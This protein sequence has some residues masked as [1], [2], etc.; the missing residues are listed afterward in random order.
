[1]TKR[2][3]LLINGINQRSN[4]EFFQMKA[5]NAEENATS[6]LFESKKLANAEVYI[7]VQKAMKGVAP[8]YTA[9][10]K[11]AA[12]Q[13]EAHLNRSHGSAVH[14]KRQGSVMTNTHILKDNDIDLVQ[15]TNKSKAVD[16]VRLKNSLANPSTLNPLEF[17][18]LK[19]H[20]D[21]FKQYGG[22]QLSDLQIL[23][24]KSEEILVSTYKEV[25]IEKDKSIY[26][27]VTSPKRDVDVV[28]ATYYK[29]IDYMKTNF[30]YRRGIQIFNK[31]LNSLSDVDYPFWSIKRI[32]ER[33]ILTNGRLK[34]MIRFL[35]NVKYDCEYINNKGAIRSFHLNAIC[36][37]I[38]VERYQYAHFLDL[39]PVINDELIRI[40]NDKTY[41]DSI[42]SVDGTEIIFEKDCD[43]KLQEIR[44]LQNEI[45]QIVTD[46]NLNNQIFI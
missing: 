46:L 21:D 14:F 32:N 35:K 30:E 33:S 44:F 25:D 1:M 41:R 2:Y 31:K 7:Y 19:K 26:I 36:Y 43:K 45:D 42:K 18:N 8:Q 39:V 23:R 40:L 17:K 3:D 22:N 15:I 34:N 38:R 4:P 24:S 37:N 10:S 16:H 9:N 6:K 11:T 27:L 13:V 12:T 20:S 29:G 5:M 28:T